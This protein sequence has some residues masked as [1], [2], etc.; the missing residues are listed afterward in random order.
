MLK[1]KKN[2]LKSKT[3][4]KSK[5]LLLE[6]IEFFLMA[7]PGIIQIFLFKYLPMFG[8]VI[9][10]K[11]FN[12]NLGIFK[13]E[14]VGF[15]NFKYFV[16]SQ[17][18]WRITRNTVLYS[19]D[20]MIVGLIAAVTVAVLLFNVTNRRAVKAYNT[21]MIFPRFISSVVVSYIVYALLNPA[22][23]ILNQVIS[24]FGG[25]ADL[26][27]Y[28]M[29]KAW[30]FILT[31]VKVWGVVGMDSIVYYASLMSI[32]D[33][34]FEAAE[35]DGAN[36]WQ[37]TRHISIPHLVPLMTILTILAFG[38]IFSGDFGLF[39][40]TTRDVGTLYPTT[41]IINTYTFRGLTGGNFEVSAAVGLL[42]SVLGL[43]MVVTVNAI[44]KKISPENSMF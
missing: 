31:Y 27:W 28:A 1:G 25:P 20:F 3:K 42:Q 19:L 38:G 11:K 30:P 6:N 35:L 24:F 29:P 34:L 21:I 14:W 2:A 36:K 15:E 16:T 37:Q 26:D 39:Y 8:I 32:D 23:G 12:P 4:Q 18:A 5:A 41:D 43:I 44:V 7:L 33:S 9:A 10:F 17:D 22:S 13:S 40:Q